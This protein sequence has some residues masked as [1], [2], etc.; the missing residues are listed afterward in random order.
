MLP[1]VASPSLSEPVLP[2]RIAVLCDL[3]DD[4]GR[5]L[6]IR[7][8]KEPNHGLYSPIGGKLDV[9][10]GESPT[11]CAHREIQEEAGIDIPIDNL[12]LVGMVSET[13]YEGSGHWLMFLYRATLPVQVQARTIN[14]GVLEW[15]EIADLDTLP[16][17]ETDRKII[18]PLLHKQAGRFFAVHIDCTGPELRW[19]VEQAD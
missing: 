3:R 17:P 7:R 19:T 13:G 9:A 1:L 2:H 16:I 14:E 18:W 6:L 8:T 5:I 12:R 11:Q 10:S 15:R 4:A